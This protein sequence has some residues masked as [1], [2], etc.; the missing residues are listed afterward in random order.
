M[1]FKVSA[2]LDI[3]L[4]EYLRVKDSAPFLDNL[5]KHLALAEM[6]IVGDDDR[7][8][9]GN[10]TGDQA[11]TMKELSLS[12]IKSMDT[13][14]ARPA[15]TN[16]RAS[17][18]ANGAAMAPL[19]NGI[20]REATT[21]TSNATAA[22]KIATAPTLPRAEA[23]AERAAH[24]H[25]QTQRRRYAT[26]PQPPNH[27]NKARGRAKGNPRQAPSLQTGDQLSASAKRR[28]LFS[29]DELNVRYMQ[30]RTKPIIPLPPV[31]LKALGDREIV[32]AQMH[33]YAATHQCLGTM[34]EKSRPR[35]TGSIASVLLGEPLIVSFRT[36]TP[37]A[38]D[39][40]KIG[41]QLTFAPAQ[42]ARGELRA[43]RQT[44]EGEAI[45]RLW[46]IGS[47]V[48]KIIS[49]SLKTTYSKLPAA[50]DEWNKIAASTRQPSASGA[51]T[52]PS[53]SGTR[54]P[55]EQDDDED[56]DEFF[57]AS[58]TLDL[59]ESVGSSKHRDANTLAHS[60]AASELLTSRAEDMKLLER[61]FTRVA[62]KEAQSIDLDYVLHKTQKSSHSAELQPHDVPSTSKNGT[63]SKAEDSKSSRARN[64][65]CCLCR[66]SDGF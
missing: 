25:E 46:T 40:A 14:H 1:K 27:T 24:H 2:L 47:L 18:G 49:S 54:V 64:V 12:E 16:E 43:T 58:S 32:P 59:A 34:Q 41:G 28:M 51:V 38:G 8:N 52:E 31:L 61:T 63:N 33:A 3:D 65:I 57:D 10:E 22:S 15:E 19:A 55:D 26:E 5:R 35:L 48:E 20:D 42:N 56:D 4:E 9:H 29:T 66:P 30:I 7:S 53:K 36:S 6:C 23:L 50:V 11:G 21:R 17:K 37:L 45:V 39:H 60:Q 62:R 13:P 44:L